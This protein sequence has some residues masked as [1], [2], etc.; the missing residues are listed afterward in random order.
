MPVEAQQATSAN[1]LVKLAIEVRGRKRALF[2]NAFAVDPGWDILLQLYA[3]RVA[4]SRFS[5]DDLSDQY[6]K[7]AL[8]RWAR[9]LEETGLAECQTDYDPVRPVVYHNGARRA[10]DEGSV[11]NW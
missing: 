4:G 1:D 6:P 5:L 11:R 7:S 10:Q 2:G 3:A 8:A 9:V